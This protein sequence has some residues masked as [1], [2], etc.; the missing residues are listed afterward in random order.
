MTS[1]ERIA[2]ILG[3]GVPDRVGR[4]EDPWGE[5]LERWHSEGLGENEDLRERFDFDL[6][7]VS[8]CDF[9]FRFER[10][11]V[12]ETDEHVIAWDA[13]GVLRKDLKRKSGFTPHWYDHKIKTR[14]D[15]FDNRG[16]LEV[17]PDRVPADIKEK[18]DRAR[19]TNRFICLYSTEPY[20]LAWPV[21][22][23]VGIFT[24]MMDDPELIRDVFE[25][26]ASMIIEVAETVFSAGGDFDGVFFY[27]DLGYRNTTLFSPALYRE[28]L[29]PQHQRLCRHFNDRG[30]PVILH[31]CG[32]IEALIPQFIE[33]G[34]AALQPIEAK[35]GMD[36]RNL[37]AEF[38]N[39]LTFY[40]NIDVR[41]LSGTRADIEEEISSKVPVAMKGG[42][43]IFHS[44]HS[45]PPTVSWENYCYAIELLDK[46][47]RY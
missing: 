24:Q 37:K 35:T 13:N 36:V 7:G 46:Y 14:T 22:G 31:S 6:G 12:E 23:Q 47:G 34:F 4:D 21:F 43:Y 9:S 16:R 33:A 38:G 28:L 8:G 27:G 42:G 30:K 5:T 15:W 19:A 41:K 45:V 3:G 32:K 18:C 26:Y 17:T 44:D 10:E 29:F 20:E 2:T 40:G 39:A 1:R 11:V 25:T